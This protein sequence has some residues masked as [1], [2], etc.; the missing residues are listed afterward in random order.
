MLKVMKA[1][2]K[3]IKFKQEFAS[4]RYGNYLE[5]IALVKGSIPEMVVYRSGDIEVNPNPKNNEKITI[6]P[7]C[8]FSDST[9]CS[10]I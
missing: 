3:E 7:I 1:H 8:S 9:E 2:K 5:F 4:I 10:R 6:T